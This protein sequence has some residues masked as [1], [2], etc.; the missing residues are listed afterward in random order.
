MAVDA[1][2]YTTIVNVQAWVQRGAFTAASKPSDAQV[3]VAMQLR[4]SEITTVLNDQGVFASPPSGGAPL[5]TATDGEKALVNL[6]DLANSLAAAGDAI[7][8]HDT[9]DAANVERAKALWAEAELKRS[10]LSDLAMQTLGSAMV[11]N[12]T[13]SGGIQKADFTEG[14]QAKE[15]ARSDL[16]D[17]DQRW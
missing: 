13:S 11:R 17:L 15:T 16:F 14:G 2:S 9:R 6:C 7:F 1:D 4:A 10:L 8:M 5:P 12:S 3:Y